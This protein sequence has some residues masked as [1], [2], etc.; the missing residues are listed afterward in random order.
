M[1]FHLLFILLNFIYTNENI[2]FNYGFLLKKDLKSK[3]IISLS[4]SSKIYSGDYIK[5]NIGY[6]ENTNFYIIYKSAE[7][8]FILLK[9]KESS[10]IKKSKIIDEKIYFTGLTWSKL[11]PPKGYEQFYF[12][13]SNTILFELVTL[14]E[15]YKKAPKRGK[16]K[17]YK[18]IELELNKYNPDIKTNLSMVSSK[19]NKPI[20]GGVTFRGEDDEF[21]ELSLTHKFIGNQNIAFKKI[22]LIHE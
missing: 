7:N 14:L 21:N 18:K 3:N 13:N 9:N 19:L 16:E 6:D 15:K 22:T 17:L 12:I 4:D 10:N 8:E 11:K 5:I 20:S 1:K 2:E